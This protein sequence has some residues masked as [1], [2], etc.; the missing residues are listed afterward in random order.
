MVRNSNLEC[1]SFGYNFTLAAKLA[2]MESSP[3][4]FQNCVGL[5]K[6]IFGHTEDTEEGVIEYFE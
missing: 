1:Q 4:R 5:P 6:S 2:V 3:T